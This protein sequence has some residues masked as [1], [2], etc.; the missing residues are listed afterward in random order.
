[1]DPI[2]RHGMRELKGPLKHT[3]REVALIGALVGAGTPVNEAIRRVEQMEPRWVGRMPGEEWERMHGGWAGA[4]MPG[5]MPGGMGM[6]G[7]GMTGKP[8]PPMG[9]PGKGVYG[10]AGAGKGMAGSA[11][12]GSGVPGMGMAAVGVPMGGMMPPYGKSMYGGKGY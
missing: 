7:M 2:V 12:V 9:M 8:M 1:M 4:G 3:L 5:M 10:M 6:P 11:V